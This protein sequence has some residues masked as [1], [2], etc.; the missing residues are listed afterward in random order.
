MTK[1]RINRRTFLAAVPAVASVPLLGPGMAGAVPAGIDVGSSA[2]A[3]NG[4]KPVRTTS[5]DTSCPGSQ[6]YDDKEETAA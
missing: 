3:I 4:G 1:V 6:F 5:L 2:L